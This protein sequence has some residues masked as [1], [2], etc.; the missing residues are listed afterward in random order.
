MRS[1]S[2]ELAAA[3]EAT[4]RQLRARGSIDW[5][6]DGHGGPGTIDD[7]SG[8]LGDLTIA[9]AVAGQLPD[10]VLVVEGISAATASAPLV[11]GK[12]DDERLAAVQFWSRLNPDSPLH[13][14][15]RAGRNARLDLDVLTSAGLESVPLL[16]D[17]VL[18]SLPVSVK[19]R[20]AQLQLLDRRDR[21]R[22]PIEL[23][24]LVADGPYNGSGSPSKPG[25]EAAWPVSLALWRCG[26]PL[27]PPARDECRLWYP[28]HGSA[29]PFIGRQHVGGPTSAFTRPT[30]GTGTDFKRVQF[31]DDAPFFLAISHSADDPSPGTAVEGFLAD[32]GTAMWDS[33]GRSSGRIEVWSKIPASPSTATIAFYMDLFATD[34]GLAG[35]TGDNNVEFR[36]LRD[37]TSRLRLNAGGSIL[38]TI[39]GPTWTHDGDWHLFGVHWDDAAG[40]ATFRRDSTSNVVAYTAVTST[41]P[42]V[43]PAVSYLIDARVPIAELQVTTGISTA[44]AWQ[45]TTWDSGVVCDRP[46]NRRLTGIYPDAPIQAWTL[47]Q[48]VYGAERGLVWVDVDGV[49]QLWTAARLNTADALTPVRTVASTRDLLSLSYRD[50]RDMIRN[51]IRHPYTTV[52][53]TAAAPLWTLNSLVR[54]EPGQTWT[55][56]VVLTAPIG[57]EPELVG[58]ASTTATG[59]GGSQWPVSPLSSVRGIV[60][61]TSPTTATIT[62]TNLAGAP[63]YLS[64]FD[65]DPNLALEGASLSRVDGAPVEVRDQASID[66]YGDSPLEVP[67]NPWSQ[68]YGWALGRAYALLALLRHEQLVY[69]DIEIPG[70]PRLEPLDRLQVVDQHGLKL[71]TEVTLLQ[72]SDTIAGGRYNSQLIARP[73][74]NQ[75]L[76]GGPGVGTPLGETILGGTP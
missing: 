19:D 46:Q 36:I 11:G 40:S 51:I 55:V 64:T 31:S 14:K 24:A 71:D 20:R 30:A 42:P 1:V 18:R 44:T 68:T 48:Q 59:G 2:A 9:R 37:G 22:T 70:D 29:T 34:S 52:S 5:D 72:R 56:D 58:T 3:I 10:E 74:R 28:M 54:V 15:P 13:G 47:L 39:T 16:V 33:S 65:G 38:R 53:A 8:Q 73:A 35:G 49:P 26:L 75:W 21:F 6:G 62:V 66:A 25:L 57:G 45:P 12:T 32:S 17:G 27:S 4:E 50:D 69:T 43:S 23:P 67:A 61:V 63:V 60:T 76:L 7:I 41:V